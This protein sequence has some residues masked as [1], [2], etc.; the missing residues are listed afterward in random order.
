MSFNLDQLNFIH[1]DILKE[2]GN[3]GAGNAI[4]SLARIINKKVNMEVPK[5]RILDFK[6]VSEALGQ[7]DMVVSGIYFDLE[8]ELRGNVLLILNSE[9][10]FALLNMLFNRNNYEKDITQLDDMEKSAV[11]EIGNILVGSYI[12]AISTFTNFKLKISPPSLAIDMAG[13]ILSVPAIQF[14]E[15][16]DKVLFIETAFSEGDRKVIGD[17]FL[18][19]DYNSY[20]KLLKCFGVEC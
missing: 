1:L 9:S 11:S 3:I 14:G 18:I 13:A 16:S 6:E 7:A 10:T 15:I 20:D 12:T 2:I 17:F 5:V 4:T 8:G 19:P